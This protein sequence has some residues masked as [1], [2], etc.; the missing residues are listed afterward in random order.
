MFITRKRADARILTA[1]SALLVVASLAGCS[2]SKAAG[3]GP[4][5]SSSAGGGPGF[6][7][8]LA[9][10][11]CMRDNGVPDYP[12][13]QPGNGGRVILAPGGSSD[14]PK[15]QAAQQACRDKMPQGVG[16]ARGGPVDTAKVMAWAQCI[17]ANGVPNFP[18]PD[19]ANGQIK[20]NIGS[21]GMQPDDPRLAKASDACKDKSPGGSLIFE[22]G[23]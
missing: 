2:G 8:A 7:Q 6:Q 13:P 9:Y 19:V 12:D 21:L 4:S 16:A 20:I 18:D 5:G 10:A 23:K 15:S 22:D 14:N 17:R 1:V 3:G 11:K